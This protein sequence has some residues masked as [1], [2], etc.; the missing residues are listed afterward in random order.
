[1]PCKENDKENGYP[2]LA[3]LPGDGVPVKRVKRQGTP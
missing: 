1:M 2:M 3:E